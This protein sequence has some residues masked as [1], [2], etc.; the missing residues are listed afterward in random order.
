MGT[1]VFE[2][3][4]YQCWTW[5]GFQIVIQQDS[6]I[7]NRIGLDMYRSPTKFSFPF[8]LL[9]H[10]QTPEC[11]YVKKCC[12]WVRA[13]VLSC[14]INCSQCGQRLRWS[15]TADK[16]KTTVS[17]KGTVAEHNLHAQWMKGLQK[18]V[19][20]FLDTNDNPDPHENLIIT[21]WPI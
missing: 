16:I 1:L 7:K 2:A 10:Y 3:I 4:T 12:F 15:A 11:F 5:S 17:E 19:R 20:W 14:Y 13:T 21:F 18:V 9:R 6:A 8:S